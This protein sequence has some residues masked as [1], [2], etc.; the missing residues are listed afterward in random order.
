MFGWEMIKV[1]FNE[2]GE[3]IATFKNVDSGEVMEHPFMH[4]NI[5]PPS[6]PHA[7]LVEAGITDSTGLVDVNP[8]TLQHGRFENIFAFGDCIKG[9]TTRTQHAAHAQHP[10]VKH[11]VTQFMDGKELNAVYDG[12]TYMPFYLSHSNANNFQHYY[13]FE[14]AT[15]NHWV[16]SFGLFSQRYFHSQ[17]KSNL[18]QGESL[19]SFK[20]DNGPPHGW[21]NAIYDPLEANE[22]LLE[23][24][25]DIEALKSVHKKGDVAV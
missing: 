14:P 6:K 1:H 5:N 9:A 12:Y 4:M 17:M 18:K 11:N 8:Y 22:Y 21:F 25:V 23:K 2:Y 7:E 20:K 13:D 3:K 10:V 15:N 24:K 19:T 16:P